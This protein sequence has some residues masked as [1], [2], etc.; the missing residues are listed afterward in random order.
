[1]DNDRAEASGSSELASHKLLNPT[2]PTET[3]ELGRSK[4]FSVFYKTDFIPVVRFVVKTQA[5]ATVHEAKD[6]AQTAFTQAWRDWNK[7]RNPRAWVRTVATRAYLKSI[8]RHEVL[9]D[10]P[11]DCPLPKTSQDELLISEGTQAVRDLLATLPMAQRLAIAWATDGFSVKEIAKEL[12]ATP[13]AVRQN[14][15]RARS[16]LKQRLEVSGEGGENEHPS[17]G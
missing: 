6:A 15:S 13:T 17:L 10:T 7:I 5:K 4:Q 3:P 11:V 9:S 1:V 14:I 16:I 8:P 12:G 2:R